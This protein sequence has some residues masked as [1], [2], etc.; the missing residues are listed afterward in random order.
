[1][2]PEDL[3]N[4]ILYDGP[5]YG[6]PVAAWRKVAIAHRESLKRKG[7]RYLPPMG[8]YLVQWLKSARTGDSA[9][10]A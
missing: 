6:R 10:E 3:F 2:I 5:I 1:M 9:I 4:H 7:H 8:A